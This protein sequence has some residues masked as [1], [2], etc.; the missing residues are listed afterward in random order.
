MAA[1]IFQE[2]SI[3]LK[4]MISH[5]EEEKD[6]INHKIKN[7]DAD[8]HDLKHYL[9][10]FTADP[11]EM[12]QNYRS[13]T[14]IDKTIDFYYSQLNKIKK[15]LEAPYF[16]RIDFKFEDGDEVEEFYIGKFNLTD[17]D[18]DI[19]IYDW[20]AP[21]SSMYY[22]Y[23]L[24]Q[25]SYEAQVGMIHGEI[26]R[27]RQ[28]KIMN[29]R[30][31]YALESSMTIQDDVLQKELS[32]TSDDRMKTIISTIQKEQNKIVRNESAHTLVIQGVA[33]SG[34]SAIALHRIAYLLYRHKEKLSSDQ[35]T[36]ISPNKIFAD[37]IANV[38]PEL[39]EDPVHEQTFD[40]IATALLPKNIK[41]E[42]LYEQTKRIIEEPHSKYTLRVKL[43]SSLTFFKQLSNYI[44]NIDSNIFQP[45][46][47]MHF[48]ETIIKKEYLISR[49]QSYNKLPV[50]QRLDELSNDVLDIIKASKAAEIKKI[51]SKIE[52]KK[53]LSSYLKFSDAQSIYIH[54]FN[55]INNCDALNW[56]K[57]RLEYQDVFPYIYCIY[58]FE[59]IQSFDLVK[60]L[61]IDE[62]QDYSPVH[63][64]VINKLFRCKK[65]ILGDFGQ[66]LNPFSLNSDKSFS[67]IFDSMEF[68]ELIKSYRSSYEI[69][70]FAKQFMPDY[71]IEA[72][73]RHGEK[74][75]IIAYTNQ[76]SLIVELQRLI[77]QFQNNSF[78][79]LGIICKSEAQVNQLYDELK[80]FFTLNK[81]SDTSET[82]E[83]GITVTT[84]Q[85]AKG[86]EFDEVIIPF[87]NAD[88]YKSK[89]DKGLLYIAVTRAMHKLTVL[90]K[91][92]ELTPLMKDV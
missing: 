58:Y 11:M 40:D 82:F 30:L 32:T 6:Y 7:H 92:N 48:G 42:S 27:K 79:R 10:E 12:Y 53:R 86:L 71:S 81:L 73:D 19:L 36:I 26:S 61:V 62:M 4:E 49:F 38:L 9:S 68:V 65:T 20:R 21:I 72:I 57:E 55:V 34:K 67:N 69:I 80:Q 84:I 5:L 41:A 3:R 77:S 56:S 39:G 89:F 31:Q 78:N 76:H 37:F 22:E 44:K 43:K 66:M 25:A 59:G 74:P 54:F 8:Y 75:E 14:N 33:G 24:G 15:L 70:E 16:G 91:K 90:H 88:I 85:L 64:A 63:Y 46:E 83:Q 28:Y 45:D 51:P 50:K 47:N 2:E 87:A 60:H 35:I 17:R 23:E 1:E 13:M 29:K 18:N 52:L